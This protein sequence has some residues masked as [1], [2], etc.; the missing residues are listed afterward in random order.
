[1]GLLEISGR[2]RREAIGTEVMREITW[3]SV[4]LGTW[5]YEMT[6][7]RMNV[8]AVRREVRHQVLADRNAW[9]NLVLV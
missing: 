2:Q 5:V 6:A 1:M 4:P 8:V 7:R 9:G 3:V